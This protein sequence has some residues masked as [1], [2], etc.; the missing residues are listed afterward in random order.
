M[1][2]KTFEDSIGYASQTNNTAPSSF[3]QPSGY[4]QPQPTY[5]SANYAN[6]AAV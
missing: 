3:A 2:K 6:P 4:P 5:P 1:Q